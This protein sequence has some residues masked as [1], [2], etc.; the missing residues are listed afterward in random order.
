[1]WYIF[2]PNDYII[3]PPYVEII[4]QTE[5]E[6]ESFTLSTFLL[7]SSSDPP[8]LQY[9]IYYIYAYNFIYAT[10]FFEFVFYMYISRQLSLFF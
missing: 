6:A 8:L 2:V 5:R 9:F 10:S 3:P 4:P 1:M 7:V